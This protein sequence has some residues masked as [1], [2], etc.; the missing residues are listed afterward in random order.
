MKY[1]IFQNRWKAFKDLLKCLFSGTIKAQDRLR[2]AY[3]KNGLITQEPTQP[4]QP[5]FKVLPSRIR[6]VATPD[7]AFLV[8]APKHCYSLPKEIH[9]TSLVAVFHQQVKTSEDYC[10][11]QL[12]ISKPLFLVSLLFLNVYFRLVILV[13]TVS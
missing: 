5:S 11:T 8:T 7:G 2:P 4:R 12:S 10:F 6:Q 3:L 9:L 13:L 1:F